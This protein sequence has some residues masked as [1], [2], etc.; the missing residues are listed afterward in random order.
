MAVPG[1]VFA[2]G[3]VF[4]ITLLVRHRLIA[5][6]LA[7]AA[8]VGL[9]WAMFTVPGP[10]AG[11]FDFIGAAQVTFPS[12]F[13]SGL[14][15][16]GG[17]WHRAGFLAM[18]LGLVGIAAAIHPR[19]DARKSW[20]PVAGSVGLVVAGCRSGRVRRADALVR[21]GERRSMASGARGAR[22]RTRGRHRFDRGHG[23][24]RP[25][26]Q[27]R[28]GSRPRAASAGGAGPASACCSR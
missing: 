2:I 25:R 3:L 9:Y 4:V 1:L 20:T 15:V 18:G 6:L 19:L 27:P 10:V 5:A 26:P 7:I 14:L 23:V 17:W 28:G 11:D 22:F 8:I 21:G 24:D 12:D 16:P 13:V